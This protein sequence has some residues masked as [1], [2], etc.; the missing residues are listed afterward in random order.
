MK[1][2]MCLASVALIAFGCTT[3]DKP[4]AETVP[5]STITLPYTP[6][7]SSTVNQDISD[8]DLLMVLKS[9]KDW[10]TG[11][12]QSLRTAFTDSIEYNGWDGT[13]YEGPTETLLQQWAPSRDS[14]SNVKIE[15]A[16]WTKNNFPDRKEK[17]ITVWYT[18]T[19]TYKDGRVIKFDMHDINEVKDGKIVWYAQYRRGYKTK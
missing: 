6:L 16:V 1:M 8:E 11:D 5:A 2:I 13:Y 14:L 17:N 7:Y 18:E 9:Y 3:P 15:M 12:M 10:E 4:A 19:D